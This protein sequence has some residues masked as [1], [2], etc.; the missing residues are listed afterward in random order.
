VLWGPRR[1]GSGSGAA[2]AAISDP[3]ERSRAIFTEAAKVLTHPRCM[4]CHPATDRPLQGNDKHPHQP[5][6]GKASRSARFAVRSRIPTATAAATSRFC[7]SIWPTMI[8]LHG[9]G[10]R[11]PDAI[12][13]GSQALLGELIQAWI[14]TGAQ[15]P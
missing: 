3:A 6:R 1:I 15:C 14:D 8:W 4:N 9:A 5:A 11:A 10:S 7:T 13:P 12:P 2:F